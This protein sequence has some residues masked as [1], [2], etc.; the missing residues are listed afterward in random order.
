MM[1]ASDM[2]TAVADNRQYPT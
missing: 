1:T 2:K